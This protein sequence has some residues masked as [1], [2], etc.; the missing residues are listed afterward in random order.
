MTAPTGA[1]VFDDGVGIGG[2]TP[3]F[4]RSGCW[5][6]L[7]SDDEAIAGVGDAPIR[8]MVAAL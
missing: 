3:P 2:A 8:T 7:A 6:L 5:P 4:L 1:Y